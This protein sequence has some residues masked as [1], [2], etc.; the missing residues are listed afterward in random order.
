[1]KYLLNCITNDSQL[2]KECFSHQVKPIII[3]FKY[4]N[5]EEDHDVYQTK[6]GIVFVHP[7]KLSLEIL[8][9]FQLIS[10]GFYRLVNRHRHH[11]DLDDVHHFFY[12]ANARGNYG[13]SFDRL[14]ISRT[15]YHL[16]QNIRFFLSGLSDEIPYT[17]EP[18]RSLNKLFRDIFFSSYV[19]ASNS[20][21]SVLP[22]Q[23]ALNE[24]FFPSPIYD[25]RSLIVYIIHEEPLID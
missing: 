5:Q 20:Q 16:L 2:S 3:D 4:I 6:G 25:M 9:I 12:D 7:Q 23:G 11:P 8:I 10:G 13:P 17:E 21:L 18:L 22:Q 14:S 19:P 24:I 15:E 1:M